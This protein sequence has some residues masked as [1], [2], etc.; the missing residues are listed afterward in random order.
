MDLG[1]IDCKDEIKKFPFKLFNDITFHS[2][3]KSFNHI[4]AKWRKMENMKNNQDLM[5]T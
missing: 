1:L 3:T 4:K 2:T 5:A